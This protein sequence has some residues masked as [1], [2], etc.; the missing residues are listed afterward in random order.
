[1]IKVIK[2]G[3]SSS[4]SGSL[5]A[6]FCPRSTSV[7]GCSSLPP[8]STSTC[9]GSRTSEASPAASSTKRCSLVS[10]RCKRDSPMLFLL[11]HSE[12]CPSSSTPTPGTPNREI[13][14]Y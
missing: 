10:V 3:G 6:P 9:T 7:S 2:V 13:P 4:R 11:I 5:L 12:L 14:E 8:S 1:M